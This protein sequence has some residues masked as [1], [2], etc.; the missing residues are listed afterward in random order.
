MELWKRL[1]TAKKPIV[2]YG[3]GNGADRILDAME[4][5]L[6]GKYISAKLND[7][8]NLVATKTALVSIDGFEDL[9]CQV[10][11]ALKAHGTKMKSGNACASPLKKSDIDACKYCSLYPICRSKNK[12]AEEE[13]L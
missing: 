5:G 11:D 9:L 7:K 4:N 1:K 2:L 3:M 8:G 10:E 12:N 6:N 13:N